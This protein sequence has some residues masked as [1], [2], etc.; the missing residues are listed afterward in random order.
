VKI[1]I[2]N[3]FEDMVAIQDIDYIKYNG[4]YTVIN[5]VRKSKGGIFTIR[6]EGWLSLQEII[7]KLKM[8]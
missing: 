5:Y 2:H 1:I 6:Y 3:G 8:L 7:E 4:E